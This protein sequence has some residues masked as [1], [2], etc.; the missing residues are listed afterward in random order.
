MLSVLFKS[1]DYL[2]IDKPFDVRMD[3]NYE[4]D[5]SFCIRIVYK[6]FLIAGATNI[7]RNG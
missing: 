3:G 2:A 4:G 6:Y 1:A 7:A 5:A